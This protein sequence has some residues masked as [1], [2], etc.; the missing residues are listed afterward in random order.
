MA[1][2][3]DLRFTFAVGDEPFEVVEFTLR[4]GL[5]ETFLLQVEL[6]SRNAAIDFGRVLD[7]NGLL[8]IWQGAR[9][10]RYVHGT[11][12]SFEQGDTGFRRTRYSAV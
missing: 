12:S 1:T 7:H 4:E 10:V 8:T 2:S 5:S 9:P 6:A 11:V 3:S